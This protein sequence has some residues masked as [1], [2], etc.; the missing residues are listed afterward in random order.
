MLC[1]QEQEGRQ[2]EAMAEG[3]AARVLER[4][5]QKLTGVEGSDPLSVK[6]QVKRLLNEAR[7]PNRLAG[8]YHGWQAWL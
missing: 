8:L 6:G 3:Q 5:K 2:R 1:R 4:L 7:D